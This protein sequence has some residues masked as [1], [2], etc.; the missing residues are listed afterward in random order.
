LKGLKSARI[1][2]NLPS[3]L[4]FKCVDFGVVFG[5]DGD[6]SNAMKG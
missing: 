5:V 1:I 6:I 4:A 3:A 2:S